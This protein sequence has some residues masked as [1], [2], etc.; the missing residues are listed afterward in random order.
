MNVY[1]R[2]IDF[3]LQQRLIR[4]L[5]RNNRGKKASKSIRQ[6]WCLSGNLFWRTLWKSEVKLHTVRI[7]WA[8]IKCSGRKER[9]VKD[10]FSFSHL[11]LQASPHQDLHSTLTLKALSNIIFSQITPVQ[12]NTDQWD[13]L[14][15]LSSRGKYTSR[16]HFIP[17][18]GISLP[19]AKTPKKETIF[20]IK[21][22]LNKKI[23]SGKLHG[24]PEVATPW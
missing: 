2:S 21:K 4:K 16:A 1:V 24:V 23:C 11:H 9:I 13:D 15:R 12:I 20:Y 10:W 14:Y 3:V 18:Q 22:I 8:T 19:L 17:I 6:K 5:P 7:Q